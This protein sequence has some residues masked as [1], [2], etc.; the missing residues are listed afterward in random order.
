MRRCEQ[1]GELVIGLNTDE[2]IEGYKGAAPVFSYSERER[3]LREFGFNC[4]IVPNSQASGSVLPLLNYAQ[5]DF[6]VI[7]TDWLRRDYLKQIGVTI[8]QLEELNIS[9]VYV[10]YT[11]GIST[12]EIKKRCL[13]LSSLT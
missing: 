3:S 2:F 11:S 9:L 6:L 10:P 12:T 5:P 13:A 7:G 4:E 1:L 8:D